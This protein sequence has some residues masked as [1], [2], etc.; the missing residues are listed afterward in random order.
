MTIDEG[1]AQALWSE[2]MRG[3]TVA[4]D[5]ETTGL[6]PH[7]GDRI[8]S[9]G[10]VCIDNGATAYDWQTLVNPQRDG[11]LIA[12]KVHKL[13]DEQLAAAPT[14]DQVAPTLHGILSGAR[15]IAAH[16]AR[17][18]W[19]FLVAEFEALGY[20]VPA[21]IVLDTQQLSR[22]VDMDCEDE[23]LATVA[24]AMGV[25]SVPDHTSLGDARV[26]ADVLLRTLWHG[27]RVHDWTSLEQVEMFAPVT[28][29]VAG[30]N[31]EDEDD[32]DDDDSMTL[33]ID[34]G[35]LLIEA[36]QRDAERTPEERA[37]REKYGYLT[38]W[39]ATDFDPTVWP[40]FLRDL[41]EV[42][43][44]PTDDKIDLGDN[45]CRALSRAWDRT[46]NRQQKV[47]LVPWILQAIEW[48]WQQAAAAGVCRAEYST[49]SFEFCQSLAYISP[50]EGIPHMKWASGFLHAW[51]ECGR[52]GSCETHGDWVPPVLNLHDFSSVLLDDNWRPDPE[53]VR[54]R[55]AAAMQWLRPMAEAGLTDELGQVGS[56]TF[57][58]VDRASLWDEAVE[59]A[60]LCFDNG[61]HDFGI[62]DR[63][64]LILERKVA[65]P[66]ACM[67]L[68]RRVDT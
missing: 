54:K 6:S 24:A 68:C 28:L 55:Y 36:L 46:H 67:A 13:T 4:L 10:L 40:A 35:E 8:V 65:D 30:D 42:Y 19:G 60:M 52:C 27:V 21:L 15:A 26:V 3:R 33:T 1:S 49:K 14:F 66:E 29:P 31:Y 47:E 50:E 9:I 53:T 39:D 59:V 37:I 56:E 45:W 57:Y 32:D 20:E 64:A 18:D 34:L 61:V 62:A 23:K 11:G 44:E 58:V 51:P 25:A 2:M 7:N 5:L 43:P 48:L 17:F 16:N 41:D 63:L 22:Y 12:S 38:D